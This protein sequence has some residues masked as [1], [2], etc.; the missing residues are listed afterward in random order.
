MNHDLPLK[1]LNC[2]V[3][4]I[5]QQMLIYDP[6]NRISAKKALNHIYF[7]NL[8]KSALPASTIISQESITSQES[9]HSTFTNQESFLQPSI[10]SLG[11]NTL[12]C[13]LHCSLLAPVFVTCT[14][15]PTKH[16]IYLTILLEIGIY[17]PL[18][19]AVWADIVSHSTSAVNILFI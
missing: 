4:L 17:V 2:Y 12:T 18:Q 3:H 14:V 11:P 9:Y 8:D 1:I 15:H 16:K 10:S 7:A 5:L 19:T 6:A 13:H